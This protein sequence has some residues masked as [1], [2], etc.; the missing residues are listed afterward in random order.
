MKKMNIEAGEFKQCRKCGRETYDPIDKCR[1]CGGLVLNE[2]RIRS[3][4]S[5][6]YVMGTLLALIMAAVFAGLVFLVLFVMEPPKPD[7]VR[8][9]DPVSRDLSFFAGFLFTGGL[10]A[11]GWFIRRSGRR[12]QTTA[13]IEPRDMTIFLALIGATLVA[14]TVLLTLAG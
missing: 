14:S 5:L 2:A 9:V 4:G 8:K 6:N 10:F 12:Q 13:R 1:K 11:A 7:S 3:G